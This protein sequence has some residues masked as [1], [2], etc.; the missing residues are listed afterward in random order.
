M[1]GQQGDSNEVARRL[2]RSA[3][4]FARAARKAAKKAQP[5]AERLAHEARPA[6]Q[7]FANHARP[8][9]ERAGRFVQEHNQEIRS[10]AGN[11]A[12]MM[13]YRSSPPMLRPIVS[14]VVDEMA[15]RPNNRNRQRDA[16]QQDETPPPSTDAR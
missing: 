3:G 14:I 1:T 5:E 11:S 13:A 10:V 6:A 2:G 15:K 12:R 8:A 4:K 7:R 9:A 16:G